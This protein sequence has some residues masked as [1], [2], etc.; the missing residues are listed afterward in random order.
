MRIV[1]Y[2]AVKSVLAVGC[3]SK[4]GL[5]AGALFLTTFYKRPWFKGKGRV[6]NQSCC[7]FGNPFG[8]DFIQKPQ[9]SVT[10]SEPLKLVPDPVMPSRN[11]NLLPGLVQVF[12]LALIFCRHPTTGSYKGFSQPPCQTGLC[13]FFLFCAMSTVHFVE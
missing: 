11:L 1:D 3:R 6:W 8:G 7:F 9:R 12:C 2:R 13:L 5:S 4:S 10:N